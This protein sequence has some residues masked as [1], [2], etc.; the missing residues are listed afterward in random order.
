MTN[1]VITIISNAPMKNWLSCTDYFLSEAKNHTFSSS[2]IKFIEHQAANAI[3]LKKVNQAANWLC[4]G[5]LLDEEA[6]VNKLKKKGSL[7]PSKYNFDASVLNDAVG[8]CIKKIIL[9]KTSTDYLHSYLS[10]Y[11]L[12]PSA[13]YV[14]DKIISDL[15]SGKETILREI[16]I[17]VDMVFLLQ[18]ARGWDPDVTLSSDDINYY[19]AEALAE[20][21]GYITF[22]HIHFVRPQERFELDRD[23]SKLN[24]SEI[25]A[26]G[27]KI[28]WFC[29]CE[30]MIDSYSYSLR[31]E[32]GRNTWILN[33]PSDIFEKSLRLGYIQTEL[34]SLIIHYRSPYVKMDGL[35]ELAKKL[36]DDLGDKLVVKKDN[37]VTR[38]VLQIPYAPP[39]SD[40]MET[41]KFYAEEALALDY[42][43]KEWLVKVEDLLDF[44]VSDEVFLRDIFKVQRVINFYRW[45]LIHHFDPLLESEHDTIMRSLVPYFSQ[46]DLEN[47][48]DAVLGKSSK[49]VIKFLSYDYSSGK[50][51]DVQYQ[52]IIR[53][54][55]GYALPYNIL[56]NSNILRNSLQ[57]A[58]KRF[59]PDGVVDPL[60]NLIY[61]TIKS[62]TE[63]VANNFSYIWSGIKGEIDVMALI[64]GVLFVFECKNPSLPCSPFETRTSYDYVQTAAAQLSRFR[65]V[66]N[67]KGFLSYLENKLGW[68]LE[69]TALTTT[70]IMSNRMFI[71]YRID[72]HP[73]RGSLEMVN[74]IETGIVRMNDEVHMVWQGDKFTGNDLKR[75]I[76]QDTV[77]KPLFDS[78]KPHEIKKKFGINEV[79]QKT[80]V[81]DLEYLAKDL[82]F[83]KAQQIIADQKADTPI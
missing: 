12:S 4:V 65:D 5:L 1:K 49:K 2:D 55:D 13:R 14:Y 35:K 72:G 46:N 69:G 16:T 59:Y 26:K 71:G 64:D 24:A 77:T 36:H 62:K 17:L 28:R 57:L 34:Q 54:E 68:V 37:I 56:A 33:P 32:K 22:L 23:I 83:V 41:E 73:V 19:S 3:S 18:A 29:E 30:I 31:R 11:E 38:Y 79:I 6:F 78:M 9:K 76:E 10:L 58:Q 42:F 43:S 39:I 50:I 21:L 25:L 82:G 51:F 7:R 47:Q 63:W 15:K 81:M 40:F 27:A 20:S 74:I 48:L 66:Y 52:P 75:Y 70:I 53:T 45:I 61:E 8:K 80:F 67:S 44:E 60:T